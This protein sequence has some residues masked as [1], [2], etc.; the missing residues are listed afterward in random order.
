[1]TRAVLNSRETALPPA[2]LA[3]K[4]ALISHCSAGKAAHAPDRYRSE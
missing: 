3:D 1:M 2:N 4:A